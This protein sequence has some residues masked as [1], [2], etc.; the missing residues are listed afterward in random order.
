[1]YNTP[2]TNYTLK[3]AAA[4]FLLLIY[5]F[6]IGAYLVMH[7]YW[8]YRS[9]RFQEQQ[10]A[11]NLYNKDDLVE[12][13]I[14][15]DMPAIQDWPAWQ[16]V[17]GQIKFKD[18]AYNYVELRMTSRMIYVKCVPNYKTT[19]LATN[20]IIDAGPMKS[21]PIPKKDHVPYPGGLFTNA[22]AFAFHH[23]VL[24][25]PVI[26]L[27]QYAVPYLSPIIDRHI[28]IPKQPPKH[29]C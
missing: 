15:V 3:K 2:T 5:F 19:R 28:D 1:M 27:A 6:N 7:K 17:S 16:K 12:V 23:I 13:E 29:I 4:I 20:N 8:V 26:Q 21:V 14:P 18:A 9:N 10:I 11:K 24:K 22:F 25:A